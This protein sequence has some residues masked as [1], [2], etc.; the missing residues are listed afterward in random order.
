MDRGK[1]RRYRYDDPVWGPYQDRT[2]SKTDK[3]S[4]E[5]VGLKG[6]DLLAIWRRFGIDVL[7]TWANQFDYD[8]RGGLPMSY[9]GSLIS[10]QYAGWRPGPWEWHQNEYIIADKMYYKFRFPMVNIRLL[11]H[12]IEKHQ[13]VFTNPAPGMRDSH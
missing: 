11:F 6:K 8:P 3:K 7:A 9:A 10:Q 4:T 5:L 1:K 12:L 13:L 2:Y